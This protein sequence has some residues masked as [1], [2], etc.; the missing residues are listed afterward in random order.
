MCKFFA[1][2]C[3]DCKEYFDRQMPFLFPCLVWCPGQNKIIAPLYFLH[4]CRKATKGLIA[5]TEIDCNETAMGLPPV[6][7]AVFLTANFGKTW[8]SRRN[9]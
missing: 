5:V 9:I 4:G 7:S 6:T 1:V 8:V 3:V 2:V